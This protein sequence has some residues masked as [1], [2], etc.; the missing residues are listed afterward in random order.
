VH[1]GFYLISASAPLTNDINPADNTLVDGLVQ[2]KAGLPHPQIHDVAVLNVSPSKTLVYIGEVG[3]IYVVVKNEGTYVEAFNVTAFYDSNVVGKLFVNSLEPNRETLLV[4]YWNTLNVTEGNYTLS[5]GASA[6]PG[7]VNIE[8]NKFIDGV[9]RVK[10]W[11]YPP[12]LEIPLWLLALLFLL[13][14]II[15]ILLLLALMFALL[16]RRRR[17]KKGKI[18]IPPI[19]PTIA[20]FQR[21][22]KCRV[23]GKEFLGVYTFCPYCFTFHGEDYK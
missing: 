7:E 8:N 10:P 17:K 9:V 14:M 18:V 11:T 22:K 16:Q 3:V 15:G 5:A 19:P 23:C 2:V 21:S 6:V 13:A 1:E 12:V 4:F 20:P